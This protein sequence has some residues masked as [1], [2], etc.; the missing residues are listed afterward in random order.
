MKNFLLLLLLLLSA[1]V[2]AQKDI[3]N[4][5]LESKIEN[6]TVYENG[7]QITR[8][9]KAT[10]AAGRTQLVFRGVSGQIDQ[11]SIQAQGSGNFTILSVV[12]QSSF[13]S[14]KS[15]TDERARLEAQ[16]REL[17]EKIAYE[18]AMVNVF[19]QEEIMLTKNQ[20][21]GGRTAVLKASELKESIDFQRIRLTEV[22]LKRLE[23]GKNIKKLED[24]IL[25]V[26]VRA[27]LAE[28]AQSTTTSEIIVTVLAKENIAQ[29]LL[30]V[31][32]FV[33]NAG[34]TPTYD[35]RVSDIEH[36]LELGYKANVFQYSGEDWNN[37]NLSLSTAN[38]RKNGTAPRLQTWYWGFPNN[39]DEYY[40]SLAAMPSDVAE[41][42][43][44]V[45]AMSNK[46]PLPGVT[47]MLKG[48]SLVTQTDANG[49][50]KLNIP[51]DRQKLPKTLVFRF[52][53][54]VS[55]ERNVASN[56]LNLD[57]REDTEVLNEE[58]AVGYGTQQKREFTSSLSGRAAG[59]S[60]R[61][62]ATQQLEIEEKES[63]TSQ[64]FDIKT[65]YSI[66]SDGKVYTVEIKNQ[67]IP[68][69][70]EYYCLP[71]IDRDAFLN[72]KIVNW[73]KYNLL[74]GDA[75]LFFEGVF[76]GK[77]TLTLPNS[78]TLTISLGR[79]KAVKVTRT[80]AADFTKKQFLGNYKTENRR[81][82]I[83]VRNTKKQAIQLVIEDQFP[84]S[85]TKEIEIENKTAPDAQINPETGL[86][87]WRLRVEPAQE[88]KLNLSYSVKFPKSGV[89]SS[90]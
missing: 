20:E 43:G 87:S 19:N 4:K 7:A 69:Y 26:N 61:G 23:I 9:A 63:P 71:K 13:L 51:P 36:D 70:Y 32:Y 80:K 52:I 42:V 65:P 11:Q 29:T 24:E 59:I 75:N 12:N 85:R 90:E 45:R 62:K 84:L 16:K 86:I 83:S 74:P 67:E 73:E 2:M 53:G 39:Y 37:V 38:P 27:N 15:R 22:A 58:V 31:S 64:S 25:A 44:T 48:T 18:K 46:T 55:E 78:D 5:V 66:P 79:D 81:Y 57:M 6:V 8:T 40:N 82:E 76:V 14:E 89:V 28:P 50:Y 60:I 34:W 1:T 77:S 54:M 56:V 35:L 47:I 68:V 17:E 10:L 3:A 30:S 33:Q 41:I 21:I 72:A 88:K 49:N